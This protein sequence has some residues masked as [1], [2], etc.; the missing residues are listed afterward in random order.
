[1]I[2]AT[3]SD[4][5]HAVKYIPHHAK[6]D[7]DHPDCEVGFINSIRSPV[8]GFGSA[9]FVRYHAGDTA[10]ATR[11]ENLVWLDPR[12]RA[13]ASEAEDEA[14][15]ETE[16]ETEAEAEISPLLATRDDYKSA[17]E[18]TKRLA[19]LIDIAMHGEEGAAE[20][21]SL[22]DLVGPARQMREIGEARKAFIKRQ[23][24]EQQFN[25]FLTGFAM[26]DGEG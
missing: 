3:P 8:D 5:G 9:V 2:T 19:R 26:A 6:G 11:V 22:C 16:D 1:M 4:I 24:Q 20:Q 17:Y 18:D 7:A 15:D 25:Q 21:A 23:G 14:E 12:R 13:A 10:A